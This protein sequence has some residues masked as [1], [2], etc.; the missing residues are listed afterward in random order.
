[1]GPAGSKVT[2]ENLPSLLPRSQALLD[3]DPHALGIEVVRYMGEDKALGDS[4]AV[5]AAYHGWAPLTGGYLLVQFV[6]CLHLPGML[7]GQIA[8]NLNTLEFW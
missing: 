3:N 7:V 6:L 1:M 8:K 5:A 2:S 4:P